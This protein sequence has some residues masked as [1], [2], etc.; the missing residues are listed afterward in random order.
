M[1]HAFYALCFMRQLLLKVFVLGLCMI[2]SVDFA[3]AQS[4]ACQ[5]Y[6]AEL[7]NLENSGGNSGRSRQFEAAARRQNSELTR[8]IS[9]ARQIG[10]DRQR[11]LFFGEAPP[12]ECGNINA[13]INQMRANL[14]NLESQA[15]NT[16][17]G[18]SE[19]RRRQI[20][21]AIDQ[22]CRPQPLT[23]TPDQPRGFLESIFGRQAQEPQ[24]QPYNAPPSSL[25]ELDEETESPEEK[26][27]RKWGGSRMVCVRAC[28]GYFFPISTYSGGRSGA[29]EMCQALC[30]ASETSAYSMSASGDIQNAASVEGKP[31]SALPNASTFQK[32]FDP[33]CSCRK[34]GQSW[35]EA[36][37]EAEE[38]LERRRGDILVTEAKAE[39][40]S[41]VRSDA[42]SA[43]D[44][45]KK[46]KAEDAKTNTDPTTP[47]VDP[48]QKIQEISG[49]SAPT[50]SNESSGIGPQNITGSVTYS[51]QEG[52][53]QEVVTQEGKKS[54]R[55]ISLGAATPVVR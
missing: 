53:K 7:A 23:A 5:R 19:A 26:E 42:T 41:R 31:Y 48:A 24:T 40:L 1:S 15:E 18:G 49:V 50:A 28:D 37:Q 8:T 14:A 45:K 29:N 20:L 33:A 12:P 3:G 2:Y 34:Q 54:V 22:N 4:A 11:V 17:G 21:A 32:S 13:R 51:T 30:P 6:R 47:A 10:C 16:S 9:Y 27:K 25:L 46:K 52:K 35:V 44:K 43:L 36:L 39:E 55:V 38:L